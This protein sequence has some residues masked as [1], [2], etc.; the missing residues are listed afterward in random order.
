VA[1]AS[2]EAST[3]STIIEPHLDHLVGADDKRSR[4]FEADRLAGFEV[5]D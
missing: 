3:A 2:D 1:D 4:N 5:E